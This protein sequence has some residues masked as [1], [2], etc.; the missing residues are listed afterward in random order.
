M[1]DDLMV[2][3]CGVVPFWFCTVMV[4]PLAT[5]TF[6]GANWKLFCVTVRALV[7]VAPLLPLAPLPDG[8]AGVV[9]G[10]PPGLGAVVVP[11]FPHAVATSTTTRTPPT[12][13]LRTPTLRPNRMPAPLATSNNRPHPPH[14][15][16][17]DGTSGPRSGPKTGC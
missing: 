14:V 5:V 17:L 9:T 11:L 3:V 7:P 1:G 16:R 10:P 8:P 6:V 13:A 4:D 2:N 12:M 15:V